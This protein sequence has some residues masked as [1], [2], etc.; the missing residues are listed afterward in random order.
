MDIQ[1]IYDSVEIGFTNLASWEGNYQDLDNI[2]K[3]MLDESCPII[4]NRAAWKL[5]KSTVTDTDINEIE[6]LTGKEFPDSYKLFLKYKHFYK[7]Y[8]YPHPQDVCFFKH[9]IHGWKKEFITFYSYDWVKQLL[10][11]NGFIPFAS[12]E[13]WGIICF[14]TN[15]NVETKNYPIVMFDQDSIYDK[16]LSYQEFGANFID[17]LKMKCMA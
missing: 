13:D 17:M 10:L 14:D 16:P 11:T 4:E 1:L 12:H 15:R 8:Y 7:L 9:P 3:E 5:I 2:A 6:K